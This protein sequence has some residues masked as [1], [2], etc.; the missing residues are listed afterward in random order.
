QVGVADLGAVPRAA[1]AAVGRGVRLVRVL[2]LLPRRLHGREV[3][4]RPAAGRPGPR[5]RAGLRLRTARRAGERR[6]PAQAECRPLAPGRPDGAARRAAAD[7][8]EQAALA[9]LR[10]EPPGGHARRPA[11]LTRPPREHT[12]P[13]TRNFLRTIWRETPGSKR[14]PRRI[15]APSAACPSRSTWRWSPARRRA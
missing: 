5:V 9:R 4:H 1:R 11:R 13:S 15:D 12:P 8:A 2:R 14:S 6:H 7:G 10:R 3:L